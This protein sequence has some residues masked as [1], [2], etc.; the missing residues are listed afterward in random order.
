LSKQSYIIGLDLSTQPDMT[1]Y[2]PASLL[3][4]IYAHIKNE[5]DNTDFYEKVEHD[6]LHG[7]ST[8]APKG[9]IKEESD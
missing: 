7:T 6:I 3:H 5:L 1:A 4:H 2:I 8:K 9:M